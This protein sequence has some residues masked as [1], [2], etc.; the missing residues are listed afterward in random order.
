MRGRRTGSAEAAAERPSGRRLLRARS[1]ARRAGPRRAVTASLVAAVLALAASSADAQA[2][3]VGNFGTAL[4]ALLFDPS[5]VAGANDWSCQPSAAHPFPV[6]LVHETAFDMGFDWPELSPM[7]ANAGY[8]VFAL[9]YGQT[10]SSVNDTFD[11]LGPIPESAQQL[12]QFVRQVLS[13]THAAQVDI[14]GHSQGGMMPN[15]YIKYLGGAPFVHVLVGLAPSN[16][17]TTFDGLFTALAKLRLLGKT[18][19]LFRAINAPSFAEQEAGSRFETHLF[20]DGDTV[21]G[22]KYVVIETSHDEVVTPFTNAFLSGPDV[23]N[24]LIQSQCPS[25]PTG[26]VAINFDGP[27]LQDVMNALG[28]DDPSFQPQ[29]TGYGFGL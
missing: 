24:V 25:D 13:A 3:P 21:P 10:A 8:C 18:N 27:A 9:N 28:P 20:A 12:A 22:P 17:G 11:G 7:L 1:A 6:I 26:H 5:T 29:C 23:Q 2:I 15:D 4:V 14:V 16:H 19:A